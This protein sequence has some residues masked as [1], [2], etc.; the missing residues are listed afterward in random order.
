M[1]GL[2]KH[3]KHVNDM[4]VDEVI[5]AVRAIPRDQDFVWD[6]ID[7]D[8]RPATEEELNAAVEADLARRR[9][10]PLGSAKTQVA[11]RIDNDVLS[12]FKATGKGWQTRMNDALR[13][14]L[15]RHPAA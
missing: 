11:L 14:W 13:E 2:P 7:E 5:A 15:H 3:V 1:N 6:G 4:T 12:A 9:G 10:R 8:D